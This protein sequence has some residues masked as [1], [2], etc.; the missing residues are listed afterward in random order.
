M[1]H[2]KLFFGKPCTV[3]M[4]AIWCSIFASFKTLSMTFYHLI[5]QALHLGEPDLLSIAVQHLEE[6][7]FMLHCGFSME[8]KIIKWLNNTVQYLYN[9]LSLTLTL[10]EFKGNFWQITICSVF[11]RFGK[12]YI[13]ANKKFLVFSFT[14]I[15]IIFT[16]LSGGE[17]YSWL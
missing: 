17:L 10:N 14:K 11:Q 13:W 2:S 1:D 9:L 3:L 8:I 4:S 12:T 6:L 7:A 16:I 5:Y 15:S